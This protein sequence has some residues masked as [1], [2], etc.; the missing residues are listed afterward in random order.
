VKIKTLFGLKPIAN[1]L[2]L[3]KETWKD[4]QHKKKRIKLKNKKSTPGLKKSQ[5]RARTR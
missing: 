5:K 3:P 1:M 4:L 2:S